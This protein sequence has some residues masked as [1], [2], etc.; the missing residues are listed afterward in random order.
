M[1][2]SQV[3]NTALIKASREGHTAIVKALL[4]AEADINMQNEV[5]LSHMNALLYIYNVLC[6]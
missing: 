6:L 2:I 3:G 4:R 1:M 5:S